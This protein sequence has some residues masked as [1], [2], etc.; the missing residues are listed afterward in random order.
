M[1]QILITL[2]DYDKRNQK[3]QTTDGFRSRFNQSI[4]LVSDTNALVN[5]YE[6][7]YWNEVS[8]RHDRFFNCIW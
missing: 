2:I 4:P 3:F 5:G 1:I 8:D 6:F 7:N